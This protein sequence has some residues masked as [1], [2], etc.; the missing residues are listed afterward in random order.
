MMRVF[1][2][3]RIKL[4]YAPTSFPTDLSNLVLLLQF[5][6]A[7]VYVVLFVLICYSSLLLV[8]REGCASSF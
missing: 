8:P 2:M 7:R 5:F 1:V 4:V 6:F 3:V